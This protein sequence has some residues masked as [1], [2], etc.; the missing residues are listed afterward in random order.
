MY[1]PLAFHKNELVEI[2]SMDM[3]SHYFCLAK[4]QKMTPLAAHVG[5][6]SR[7]EEAGDEAKAYYE[8]GAI[9]IADEDDEL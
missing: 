2:S 5:T 7:E 9:E 3:F 4:K 6:V 8:D 1:I